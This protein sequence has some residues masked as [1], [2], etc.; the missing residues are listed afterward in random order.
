MMLKQDDSLSE[1]IILLL[2]HDHFTSFMLITLYVCNGSGGG[3]GTG[4]EEGF[5]DTCDGHRRYKWW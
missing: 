5:S 3:T 2:L 4:G 1:H